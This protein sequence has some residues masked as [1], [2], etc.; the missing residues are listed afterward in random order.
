MQQTI[1]L[2]SLFVSLLFSSCSNRPLI[3]LHA[4]SAQEFVQDSNKIKSGKKGISELRGEVFE[5]LSDQETEYTDTTVGNGDVFSI[6]IFNSHPHAWID[7]IEKISSSKGFVIQND[8]LLIPYFGV[9]DTKGIDFQTLK[10]NVEQL[11]Q[12]EFRDAYTAIEMKDRL[13]RRVEVFGTLLGSFPLLEEVST[14]YDFLIKLKVPA[15]TNF[16]QSYLSRKGHIL[17]VDLERLVINGDLSQNIFLHPKDTIFLA[18]MS[19]SNVIV[20]GEVKKEGIVPLSKAYMPIKEVIARVGGIDLSADRMF[21]QV[22]RGSLIEPKIYTLKYTQI[23]K[24]SNDAMVV[25]PGDIVYIAATPIA[26]WNRLITQ[27]MPSLTTYEFFHKG[28]QGVI[29]P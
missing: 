13:K 5:I 11:V 10:D 8:K 12:K 7:W 22:I 26:E 25:M 1:L 9:I 3:S 18:D 6:S 27:I 23:L 21:I 29:I 14:L 2:S 28:I 16:S 20:L 4:F 19:L 17:P 24:A 15:G